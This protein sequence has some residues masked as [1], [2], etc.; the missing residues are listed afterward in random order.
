MNYPDYCLEL[1]QGN[2]KAKILLIEDNPDMQAFMFE[3]LQSGG[4]QVLLAGDGTIGL[5]MAQ[6][7]SPDL[8][9]SDINL[10]GLDG[11]SILQS[12]RRAPETATI[13]FIFCTGEAEQVRCCRGLELGANAY[14]VKPVDLDLLLKT[15]GTQL[16]IASA[17]T[18]KIS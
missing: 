8:I 7:H 18:Q 15:V 2:E 1:S 6:R 9:I 12:L 5:W 4:F 13:P 3:A 17:V 16:A 10:P 14:L 11:Y